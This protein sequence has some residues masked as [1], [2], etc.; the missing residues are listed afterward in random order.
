MYIRF[1]HS[2]RLVRVYLKRAGLRQGKTT[3][4]LGLI[5]HI[6]GAI[7]T[8]PDVVACLGCSPDTVNLLD[9][10]KF[11]HHGVQSPF[12]FDCLSVKDLMNK[13]SYSVF[14]RVDFFSVLQ[15][16]IVSLGGCVSQ[17]WTLTTPELTKVCKVCLVKAFIVSGLV[18]SIL[19]F[20]RPSSHA[21]WGLLLY[22][23]YAT[24]CY[25]TGPQSLLTFL[26]IHT[27]TQCMRLLTRY[28]SGTEYF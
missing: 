3:A 6:V 14:G 13:K 4:E 26:P 18:L 21:S 28:V 5:S 17:E 12:R 16:L 1:W 24:R 20:L 9:N 27:H 19:V 2:G 11:L 23:L 8:R 7:S 25:Q 22:Q 15:Y 10:C